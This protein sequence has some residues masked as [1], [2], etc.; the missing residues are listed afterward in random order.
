MYRFHWSIVSIF[1]AVVLTIYYISMRVPMH[2]SNALYFSTHQPTF[3]PVKSRQ[4]TVNYSK[5]DMANNILSGTS[6]N[7][8][9]YT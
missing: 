8:Y 9:Q 6:C 5:A 1:K 2:L 4:L 7:L 3:Y